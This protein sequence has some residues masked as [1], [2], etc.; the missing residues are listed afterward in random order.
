MN[1]LPSRL[2]ATFVAFSLTI[3]GVVATGLPASA[4]PMASADSDAGLGVAD[5][6]VKN[7]LIAYTGRIMNIA[8]GESS[9]DSN[10][11]VFYVGDLGYLAVDF[12]RVNTSN[13]I[14]TFTAWF[15]LPDGID[16]TGS[17]EDTFALVANHS[18]GVAP[19][20]A[21][22]VDIDS[23]GGMAGTKALGNLSPVESATH[24]IYAVAVTPSNVAATSADAG[25]GLSNIQTRV[26]FAS[27]F[28]SAQSDGKITFELEGVTSWYKSSFTCAADLNTQFT[29]FMNEATPVAAAQLGYRAAP[30]TH[31]VLFF[32]PGTN[33]PG[34]AGLAAVGESVNGGGALWVT[35]TSTTPYDKLVLIHEL[36]HS[37]SLSHAD[38]ADC[39]TATPDPGLSGAAGC[40]THE[41]GDLIDLM[42]GGAYGGKTGGALSSPSAI[43]SQ[44]WPSSAYA[45]APRGATATYVL[46]SVSS[47][48]GLRSVVVSDTDGRDYFVEFRNGTNED[49]QYT[50]VACSTTY[51][52]NSAAGVRIL[53][54]VYGSLLKG[55]PG[56]HS[57]LIGRTVSSTKKTVFVQ[58]ESF[59]TNGITVNVTSVTSTTATVQVTR[60]SASVASDVVYMRRAVNASDS[61]D[62]KIRVGDT[63]TAYVGKYWNA[64][65]YTYKWYRSGKAISGATKRDYVITSADKGKTLKVAVTGTLG[66]GTKTVT[67][68][69]PYYSGYSV[70]AGVMAAGTV[71]INYSATPYVATPVSWTVPGAKLSYQWYRSGSSISGATNS[72]YTPTTSDRDK[73]FTVK[74]TATKSGYNTVYATSAATPDLTIDSSGTPVISGTPQV[75]KTL[76]VSNLSY[77]LPGGGSIASPVRGYQWYRSGSKI[78]GAVS[79]NYVLT[80]SDYGKKITAQVLGGLAGYIPHTATSAATVSVAKGVFN[81]TLAAPVV[82]ETDLATRTLTAVVPAGSITDASPSYSYQWYRGTSKISKA[83]KSYYKL[84]S[85]DY[86]KNIT[87]RVTVS[88]SN[89]SSMYLYSADASYS[90]I[91]SSTTPTITGTLAIGETISVAPVTT[92]LNG[93]PVTPD[94]T[95]RWYRNTSAISGATSS[96]YTLTPADAGK[97]IKVTVT[98]SKEGALGWSKTSESTAKL[99]SS[100]TAMAGWNAQA[101][102]TVSVPDASKVLTVTGTG[103]TEPD[104]TYAYQWYRGSSKISKAT[105]SYYKLTS[106]DAGK[107]ISVRVIA[108]KSTFTSITKTSV[109]V[110]YTV[111]ADAAPVISDTTPAVN[112]TL[113][114]IMPTYTLA[115]SPY[116]PSS[117]DFTY[118]WY[119]SGSSISGAT[120]DTYV[121]KSSDKGKTIKVKVTVTAP[122]YLGSSSTSSS[123]SK[124]I[125]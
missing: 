102:A 56:D 46:N 1:R 18:T 17:V 14:G 39:P 62:Y 96:S 111:T 123:T 57:M 103:I 75:G 80:S 43:R 89:Y 63:W 88:K 24:K 47:H 19:L 101:N 26:N 119:R 16:T 83:T 93:S 6:T 118:R 29:A 113:T 2:A 28:W 32:P 70:D 44:I 86:G 92:T 82:T 98:S 61:T 9:A 108:S 67:D 55:Y 120:G 112:D 77:T 35:G 105:K 78:T 117:G 52:N 40:G 87:V 106:S 95:Y 49:A 58:G 48:S 71:S 72:T 107:L 37:L 69:S 22:K 42:G 25:Q 116:V 125:S 76:S 122:N 84:T 27:D 7:G 36:G 15:S 51:C 13:A 59:S 124:V 34:A 38:W 64:D 4:A 30:N 79:Q 109:P 121:V 20:R 97:T 68:P 11:S 81:G 85:S 115:G 12:T 50:A 33:C 60:P 73:T 3:T 8:D 45:V 23:D 54:T 41:Y 65:S 94:F 90:L 99:G 110:N 114:I 66:S 91:P 31:L 53:R 21:T 10:V 74:V 104:V 5:G 100:T